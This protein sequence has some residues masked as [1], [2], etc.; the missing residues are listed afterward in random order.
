MID[1][2]VSTLTGRHHHFHLVLRFMP[3][4]QCGST[5]AERVVTV[6]MKE[7]SEILDKRQIRK[8]NADLVAAVPRHFLNNG[9][10]DIRE[11]YYLGRLKP[12]P[13]KRN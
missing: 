7:R 3:D 10:I 1:R 6:W 12:N 5:Y 11:V 4:R 9:G 13:P 2:L 8:M